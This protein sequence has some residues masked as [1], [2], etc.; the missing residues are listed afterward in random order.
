MT[1]KN[2]CVDC[3]KKIDHRAKRCIICNQ[4]WQIGK[5][6][7]NFKHGE[8]LKKHYCLDCKKEINWKSIRC[9][10]CS[11]KV[12]FLDLKERE[13]C[14]VPR[15]GKDN[16]MYDIHRFGSLNP[17]WIDG[18]SFEPYS[19]EFT[20]QLKESIRKRDNYICQNCNMTEKEHLIIID[21]VLD[22][23]H[24]DYDKKNCKEDNLI[25]T[26][27]WCNVKANKNRNYWK[28]YYKEKICLTV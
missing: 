25:T 26:C 6:N 20:E 27:L 22:V 2:N 28:N 14:S 13:K 4:E 7:P 18:R 1:K 10:S 19:S 16:P 3:D 5:N 23:H 21:R 17:N 12:R 9:Y 11:Q 8:T 15:F 24:I